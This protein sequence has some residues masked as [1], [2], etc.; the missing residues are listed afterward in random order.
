MQSHFNDREGGVRSSHY[1]RTPSGVLLVHDRLKAIVVRINRFKNLTG[2][3][4]S[5]IRMERTRIITDSSHERRSVYESITLREMRHSSK[6]T[7]NPYFRY[8]P[9]VERD[10]VN[11]QVIRQV[12]RLRQF[13]ALSKASRPPRILIVSA[14]HSGQSLIQMRTSCKAQNVFGGSFQSSSFCFKRPSRSRR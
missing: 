2:M 9:F 12:S 8:G 6:R 4:L 7:A 5:R 1:S 3:L 10:C 11:S 14:R 13:A